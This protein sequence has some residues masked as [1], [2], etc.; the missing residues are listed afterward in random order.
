MLPRMPQSSAEDVL[1]MRARDVG[2]LC[3]QCLHWPGFTSRSQMAAPTKHSLLLY[4]HL[5]RHPF[6]RLYPL[7][8][9][10]L[11]VALQ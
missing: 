5:Y 11:S 4:V 9:K 8:G 3:F 2:L 6:T 7:I 1:P 10:L